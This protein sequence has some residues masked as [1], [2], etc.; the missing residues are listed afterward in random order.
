[1][2]PQLIQYPCGNGKN[3]FWKI[4][5]SGNGYQIKSALDENKCLDVRGPSVD[6]GTAIQIWDC[7][8]NLKNQTFNF[9][10]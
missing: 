10:Y 2:A 1:M 5:P 9:K 4:V 8:P 7:K 6:N 3:E